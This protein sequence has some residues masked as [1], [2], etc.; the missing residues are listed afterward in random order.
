[1]AKFYT[2][3]GAK[4]S[5]KFILLKMKRI[6]RKLDKKGY[7]LRSGAAKGADSYFESGSS[8]KEIFLP[9]KGFNDNK[10]KLYDIDD[11]YFKISSLYAKDFEKETYEEQCFIAR[12]TQQVINNG[13]KSDFVICW[14]RDNATN[15]N[16]KRKRTGGTWYAIA[17]ASYL[18]IPVINLRTFFK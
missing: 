1:M 7:T 13:I 15:A 10:S 18:D 12:D 5:P 17:L 14:T 6:S 3:I 16:Y 8:R 2:G 9:F 11:E 4:R